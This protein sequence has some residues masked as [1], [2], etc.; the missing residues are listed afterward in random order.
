L[1]VRSTLRRGRVFTPNSELRT[2]LLLTLRRPVTLKELLAEKKSAILQ[3]WLDRILEVYPGGSRDFFQKNQDPFSNP[4]GSTIREGIEKLFQEILEPTEVAQSRSLLDPNIRIRAV[5]N[6]SP[7]QALA[8]IPLLKEIIKEALGDRI[9]E[10]VSSR[11]WMIL[12]GKIDQLTL[13]ALDIYMEC[14]EKIHQLK[15][16]EL[17]NRMG[18]IQEEGKP[19]N[20]FWEGR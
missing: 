20:P 12:T 17:K 4:I 11:E 16:K 7:S 18:K 3:G 13:Q 9:L 14:R 5:E 10:R 1:G 19:G 15:I 6:L 2:E 8:F